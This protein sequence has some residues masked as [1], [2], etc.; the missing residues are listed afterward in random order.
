MGRPSI[1]E[2]LNASGHTTY[3]LDLVMRAVYSLYGNIGAG[4]DERNW[5]SIMASADPLAA[6]E[7]ALV[8]MYQDS[9]YLLRNANHLVN[10]GYV[11]AQAEI[12]YRQMYDRLGLVYKPDWS[13]GTSYESLGPLTM[14]QLIAQVLPPPPPPTLSVDHSVNGLVVRVNVN[15]QVSVSV[16]GSLGNFSAGDTVLVEQ[17]SIK[18]GYL[19]LSANGQTSPATSQYVVLGTGGN[20]AIDTSASGTRVNYLFGG[21]GN[22]TLTAGSGDDVIHGGAGQDTLQGGYGAD[23]L[24]GGDGDDRFIYRESGLLRQG[25]GLADRIDGGA[26]TNTLVIGNNVGTQNGFEIDSAMSWARM[27]NVSRIEAV[28]PQMAGFYLEFGDDAHESGLRM[29]DLSSDT[30]TTGMNI[31]TINVSTETGTSNGYTLVGSAYVDRITGGAGPD[32]VTGGGGADKMLGK[33]GNDVF[34]MSED[35]ASGERINGGSTASNEVNS[36]RID[37]TANLTNL[38]ATNAD[39]SADTLY[40]LLTDG[41][42]NQVVLNGDS[43][44]VTFQGDFITG[45]AIN[46]AKVNSADT[47]DVVINVSAGASRDFSALTFQANFRDSGYHGLTSGTNALTFNVVGGAAGVTLVGSSIG[48]VINGGDGDDTLKGGTGVDRLTGGLGHNRFIQSLGDS[49]YLSESLS[50][51]ANRSASGQLA[52]GD[53]LKYPNG[54]VDI[55]TDFDSS[56]DLLDATTSGAIYTSGLLWMNYVRGQGHYARGTW[57]G[58]DQFTIDY[59]SG[60]DI[61]YFVSLNGANL[62]FNVF[63]IANGA[64]ILVGAGATGFSASN[65]V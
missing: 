13:V 9:S 49:E 64:I 17:G 8:A 24:Y 35:T 65:I 26:G 63:D 31:N 39:G 40:G 55:V 16:S 3:T 42:I 20:D 57:D 46:F 51:I 53:T 7:R 22:D 4:L 50:T 43:A 30:E 33:G 6:S 38:L 1:A 58:T 21:A 56:K 47:S 37:A 61:L 36:I 27:S 54:Q 11:P 25:L 32:V 18:E 44:N 45:Q 15:G 48:D 28:G 60:R 12:T 34:V 2:L 29:V 10:S 62:A 52:N 23:T 59:T 5:S 14:P 19:S 41:A